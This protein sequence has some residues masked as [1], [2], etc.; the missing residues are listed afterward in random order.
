M[1][2]IDVDTMDAFNLAI[3]KVRALLMAI[4]GASSLMDKGESDA[5]FLL[6]F[7]AVREFESIKDAIESA[8]GCLAR[9]A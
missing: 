5:L 3:D 6:A 1:R 7:D 2:H 8:G 9:A 4:R